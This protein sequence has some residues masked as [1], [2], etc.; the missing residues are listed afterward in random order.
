MLFSILPSKAV[1]TIQYVENDNE[2]IEFIQ[3]SSYLQ[4]TCFNL[5]I[6]VSIIVSAPQA[7]K[8]NGNL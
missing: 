5:H 1:M 8:K 6:K 2:D 4:F 7:S 3:Q